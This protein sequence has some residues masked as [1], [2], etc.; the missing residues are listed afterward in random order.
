[1]RPAERAAAIGYWPDR[2]A[3]P[4]AARDEHAAVARGPVEHQAIVSL[5]V[6]ILALVRADGGVSVGS[7]RSMPSGTSAD[8]SRL[9]AG[10]AVDDPRSAPAWQL[11]PSS[12][13][14]SAPVSRR[15]VNGSV[16]AAFERP[17]AA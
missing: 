17:P 8:R 9:R 7:V 4:A 12:H 13:K 10:A 11:I 5:L 16:R 2:Q 6:R 15:N 3:D 1:M 14:R